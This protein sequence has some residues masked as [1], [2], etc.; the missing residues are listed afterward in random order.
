[1]ITLKNKAFGVA[2]SFAVVGLVF[3]ACGGD[4]VAVND[5]SADGGNADST[6]GDDGSASPDSATS[7]DAGTGDD[8][9]DIT[10]G[11]AN[12]GDG[13]TDDGG[14]L[15]DGGECNT[16][17]LGPSLMSD[18]SST[19]PNNAG[20][21]IVAGTYTL[22]KVTDLGSKNFCANTFTAV[23]FKGALVLASGITSGS[24]S[25]MLALDADAKGRKSYDW[26]ITPTAANKSPLTV[27]QSCPTT[28]TTAKPYS[29]FVGTGAAATQVFEIIDDYGTAGGRAIFHFE[30]D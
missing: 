6:T 12:F 8:G 7:T 13:S 9:G 21:A 16:V 4:D 27:D 11:G 22:T 28:A 23:P 18:C 29:S 14:D 30:K 10:D 26:T 19:I 2:A 24:F 5:S 3:A 17:A 20:G 1:M 25:A 15:V